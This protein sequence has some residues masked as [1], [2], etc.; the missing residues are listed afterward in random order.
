MLYKNAIPLQA[1]YNLYEPAGDDEENAT[2]ITVNDD[3]TKED[4]LDKIKEVIE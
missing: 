3:M 1:F 2:N 4:V